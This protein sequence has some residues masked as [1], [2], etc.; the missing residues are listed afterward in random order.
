MCISIVVSL[1]MRFKSFRQRFLLRL[2]AVAG[3]V[4]LSLA[5]GTAQAACTDPDGEA[6]DMIYNADHNV[7][8][9]CDGTNWYAAGGSGS[10]GGSATSFCPD[11]TQG[12]SGAT[13]YNPNTTGNSMEPATD[14]ATFHTRVTFPGSPS[15]VI[16]ESGATGQG[17]ALWA[18]GNTLYFGAGDGSTSTTNNDGVIISTDISAYTGQTVDIVAAVDPDTGEAA[19][20]IDD[21]WQVSG[22]ASGGSL[23]SGE[24]A[25]GDD[26]GYGRVGSGVRNPA[27]GSNFNGTLVSDLSFYSGQLPAN[28]PNDNE[29]QSVSDLSGLTCST[30]QIAKY[31]GS[32]WVC[33][34]GAG[35]GGGITSCPSGFVLI[36]PPGV[37]SSFCISEN[38]EASANYQT[39][40]TNCFNTNTNG[41]GY[42]HLCSHSEWFKA[43]RSGQASGMT[44]NWE[45]VDDLAVSGNLDAFVAGSSNCNSLAGWDVVGSHPFRCCL[46]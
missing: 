44:G 13:T 16:L 23:Q 9:W 19:I 32:Q 4:F 40:R 17:I 41:M 25:G 21:C 1:S 36:G 10:G 39:A 35:G 34:D 2:T 7:M 22:A 38:E 46:R 30:D 3:A 5:S 11:P 29:T 33:A 42:A 12:M 14:A 26:R 45:R 8:Q 15:G 20:Y 24:W 6:G 27:P 28:F 37:A 43:C 18:D 31:D